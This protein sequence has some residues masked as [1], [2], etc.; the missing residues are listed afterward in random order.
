MAKEVSS[1]KKAYCPHCKT[2]NELD[3]IFL[4]SPDAEVCYCPNCL[5]EYRPRDVIDNYNYFMVNK[6]TKAERLLYRETKFYEAYCAFGEIIEFDSSSC[7]ARF[8]R[9]LSLIF[10]SKLR[11]TNFANATLILQNEAEQYFRKMKDQTPYV[12][13]LSRATAALD[14]YERRLHKKITIKERFYDEDCVALYYQRLYEIIE[15]KKVLLEELEKSWAKT[16]EDKTEHLI[17]SIK[18]SISFL[19]VKFE[20]VS[21]TTN[22]ICYK[23]SKVTSPNNITVKSL[24]EHLYPIKNYRVHKLVDNEKRGKLLSDKVFPDNSHI[25]AT[26]KMALPSMII[27]YLAFV[28][29][30]VLTFIT[31]NNEYDFILYII[32]GCSLAVAITWMVLFIVWKAEL[33]NRHHL[34]D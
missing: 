33:S 19:N 11:K 16:S 24:A 25:N 6:I 9:I 20:D 10:M 18:A 21:V 1:L 29:S 15:M 17:R 14:E 34:I 12:K 23:V 28:V 30:F 27:F 13:F 5:R 2:E 3:R 22:G 7:K 4:V 32:A 8:G 31:K 26:L